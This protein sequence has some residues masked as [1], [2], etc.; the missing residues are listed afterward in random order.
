MTVKPYKSKQWF[1]FRA[2]VIVAKKSICEECGIGPPARIVWQIH[3]PIYKNE[4]MPWEYELHEV[5]LVCRGCHAKLHGH[6]QPSSGWNLVYE[7]V[8][9]EKDGICDCCGRAIRFIYQIDHVDWPSMTVG[10]GCCDRLTETSAGTER[11]SF[12]ERLLRFSNKSRWTL[13]GDIHQRKYKGFAISIFDQSG[14]WKL[15]IS[16][17]LGTLTYSSR[18]DAERAALVRIEIQIAKII[19]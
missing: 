17:K 1:D 4:A 14:Q 7:D 15:E 8:L 3:H 18:S 9:D 11:K 5:M 2:S 16:S 13:S 12:L 10:S 6:I 19:N